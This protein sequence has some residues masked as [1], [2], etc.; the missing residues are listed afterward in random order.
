[1]CG[2]YCPYHLALGESLPHQP[3]IELLKVAQAAVDELGGAR[4]RAATEVTHV[5]QQDRQ[6]AAGGIAGEAAA[7]DAG[8]DDGKVEAFRHPCSPSKR[9]SFSTQPA[10]PA[11]LRE[12]ARQSL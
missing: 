6:P 8:A 7:V 5:A 2:G 3:E 1:M 4:G 12:L 9:G 11:C 10:G